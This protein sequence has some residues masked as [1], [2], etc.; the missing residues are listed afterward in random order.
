MSSS[1]HVNLNWSSISLLQILEAE[2]E[3]KCS[4]LVKLAALGNSHVVLSDSASLD[5]LL[6]NAAAE[7]GNWHV[8]N[9]WHCDEVAVKVCTCGLSVVH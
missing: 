3:S 2:A 1:N 6:V 7:E 4:L 5:V 8:V 9:S